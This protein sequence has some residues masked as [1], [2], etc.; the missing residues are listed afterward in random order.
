MILP[1]LLIS[2]TLLN[3]HCV[4][5]RTDFE[6]GILGTEFIANRDSQEHTGQTTGCRHRDADTNTERLRGESSTTQSQ[7]SEGRR[8]VALLGTG[9]TRDLIAELN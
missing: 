6:I 3:R 4:T 2:V 1:V 9:R 8:R 7:P 5:E